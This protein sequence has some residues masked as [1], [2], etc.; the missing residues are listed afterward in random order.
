MVTGLC[1]VASMRVSVP[2]MLVFVPVWTVTAGVVAVAVVVCGRL[3]LGV[4]CR[5]ERNAGR[6]ASEQEHADEG[7]GESSHHTGVAAS[8]G[9]A[10]RRTSSVVVAADTLIRACRETGV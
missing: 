6:D 10:I 3:G 9:W 4:R 2:T 5:G 1:V 7:D 8:T